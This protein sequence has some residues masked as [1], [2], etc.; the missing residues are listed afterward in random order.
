MKRLFNTK[1]KRFMIS[2]ALLI[3]GAF[4]LQPYLSGRPE[5]NLRRSVSGLE[6][7]S[8]V[9]V[10]NTL[11]LA[12]GLAHKARDFA[13]DGHD[14][15]FSEIA[16]TLERE[17]DTLRDELLAMPERSERLSQGAEKARAAIDFRLKRAVRAMAEEG[18]K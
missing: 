16:E 7:N 11:T 12:R 6:K 18:R 1:V 10:L 2:V 3:C 15:S 5:R 4:A 14:E 17:A 9:A 8:A 13:A